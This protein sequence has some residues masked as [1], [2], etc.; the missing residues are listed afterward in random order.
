MQEIFLD[1]KSS[2]TSKELENEKLGEEEEKMV[3]EKKL[4]EVDKSEEV[5]E[6]LI[7]TEGVGRKRKACRGRK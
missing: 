3:D 2:N 7:S 6:H 1:R 5:K 4:I